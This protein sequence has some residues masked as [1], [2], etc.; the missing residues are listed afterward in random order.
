MNEKEFALEVKILKK[1]E[2]LEK[3]KHSNKI[4]EIKLHHE[5]DLELEKVR[6]D[7]QM[8]HYRLKRSDMKRMYQDKESSE[9]ARGVNG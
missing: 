7:N 6:A 8:S 4:S 3:L 1:K 5:C 2:D 9:F